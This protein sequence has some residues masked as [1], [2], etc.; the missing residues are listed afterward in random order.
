M[1]PEIIIELIAAAFSSLGFA[2]M[3]RVRLRH[4]WV[5]AIGGLLCDGIYLLLRG[6]AGGEFFPCL[7]AAIFSAFFSEACAHRLRAPVQI[8]LLPVLVALVPGGFL[9]YA[10]YHLLASD[11]ALFTDY[12]LVT[13]ET[14]LGLAGGI[15]VGLAVANGF[16]SV[17]R[18]I[19]DKRKARKM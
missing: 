2:L 3:F 17:R 15:V 13:L 14:A 6:L 5:I 16:L 4:L 10:M 8:Y 11:Y 7:A 12:L 9:Y 1:L 19:A 18:R